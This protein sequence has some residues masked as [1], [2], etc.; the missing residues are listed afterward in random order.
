MAVTEEMTM[1]VTEDATEDATE[2]VT[3]HAIFSNN[4][5]HKYSDRYD[6]APT[7]S[8]PLL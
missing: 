3:T 5:T 4:I 1:V 6:R 8:T 2:D 7:P